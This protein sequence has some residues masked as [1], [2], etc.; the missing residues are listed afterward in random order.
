MKTLTISAIVMLLLG[1][2]LSAQRRPELQAAGTDLLGAL[3]GDMEKLNRGMQ[4]LEA[5]LAKDPR[6]PEVKVLYGNGLFARSG[7]AIQKGDMQNAMKFWQSALNEMAQA[8]EIAPES[9]YVRARR[10]VALISASRSDSIP[11]PMARPLIQLAVGDFVKVLEIREREQTLSQRS[12]HQRGELLT[13]LADGWNRAGNP[14][15]ARG[16]FE[17]ITRD[18]KGTTYE[19]KARAWLE[20]RPEAKSAEYFAC[21]TCHVE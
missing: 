15:K 19:Q 17:R 7:E 8:V 16:Y 9:L 1:G 20:D 6:D 11:E 18:L 5:L 12:I 3:N 14:E 21:T 2:V 4:T 10:G 13:G